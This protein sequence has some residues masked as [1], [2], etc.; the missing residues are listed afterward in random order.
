MADQSLNPVDGQRVVRR[1]I[2]RRFVGKREATTLLAAVIIFIG[3]SVAGEGF[4]TVATIIAIIRLVSFWSIV[5]VG[6][7]MLLI[8]RELDIS[9]G[10]LY[11]L[12][13]VELGILVGLR[14]WDPWLSSFVVLLT[15]AAIGLFH[16]LIVTKMGIRSLIVTIASYVTFKG[17]AALLT[18]G[19]LIVVPF[20]SALFL[21]ITGGKILGVPSVAAW[22]GLIVLVGAVVLA[23]TKFGYNIYAIGGNLQA[24]I[25]AGIKTDRVKIISFMITSTLVAVVAIITVVLFGQ[26]NQRVGTMFELQVFAVCIMG[27]TSMFGGRGSIVGT[28][29]GAVILGT[30]MKGLVYVG[31]GSYWDGIFIGAVILVATTIDAL[32]R[33]RAVK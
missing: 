10:S 5:G 31:F 28:L 1:S 29:L 13:A 14:G 6:Q 19:Y 7:T 32:T 26:A 20:D 9:V 3:F 18:G 16:G 4:L 17:V 15:G 8:G 25:N 24:A 22:M 12:L 21:S 2:L 27:G 30:I 33:R 23:Y 11:G